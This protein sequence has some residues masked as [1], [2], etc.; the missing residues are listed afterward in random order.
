MKSWTHPINDI[1][2]LKDF[3]PLDIEEA[4]VYSYGYPPGNSI[5]SHARDLIRLLD[6]ERSKRKSYEVPIAFVAHNIGG[7]IVKEVSLQAARI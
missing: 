6:D 3:L 5:D 2:W 1:C 4:N 7:L